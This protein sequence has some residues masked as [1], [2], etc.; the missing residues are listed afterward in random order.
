MEFV[1]QIGI[2]LGVILGLCLFAVILRVAV[3]WFAKT[4][5]YC[6]DDMPIIYHMTAFAV[7]FTTLLLIHGLYLTVL[8][9]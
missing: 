7:Y 8:A 2:V 3:V 9:R 5:G 6:P 4:Q 1:I